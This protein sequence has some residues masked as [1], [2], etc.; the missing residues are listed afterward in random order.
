MLSKIDE[1]IL[2]LGIIYLLVKVKLGLRLN[3]N[4]KTLSTSVEV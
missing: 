2:W 1:L 3:I 4:L